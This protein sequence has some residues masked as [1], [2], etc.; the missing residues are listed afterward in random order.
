MEIK[1]IG[2]ARI[3]SANATWPFATLSV[4]EQVLSVNASIIG[5]LS[6]RAR[7]IIS[8]EPYT[9]I[10][11]LGQGIR[12]HHSV[13]EYKDKVIFWTFKSPQE[14]IR[15]IEQT[16]FLSNAS[17]LTDP[18][19]QELER[20][21]SRG[22]FPVKPMVA[23]LFVVSWNLLL[24]PDLMHAWG[25]EQDLLPW[26]NGLKYASGLLFVTSILLLISKDFRKLIL[27]EGRGLEDIR[28]FALFSAFIS[29]MMYVLFPA[30]P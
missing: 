2:G 26:R 23:I 18:E 12:I 24:L 17:P 13:Q 11:F 20:L 15:R 30:M 27:K 19:H 1:E 16:G 6:F 21:Q 7:D 29:A 4:N 5:N 14:L 25:G 3:G 22:G 10:P 9:I 8:I 28:T